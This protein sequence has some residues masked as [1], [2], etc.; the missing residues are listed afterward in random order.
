MFIEPLNVCVPQFA[1]IIVCVWIR[2]K[3]WFLLPVVIQQDRSY[4][5]AATMAPFTTLVNIIF[6]Q[7]HTHTGKLLGVTVSS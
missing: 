2:F 7:S 4:S 6:T 1:L 5:W 3:M